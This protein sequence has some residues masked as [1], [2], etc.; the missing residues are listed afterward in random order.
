MTVLKKEFTKIHLE[1]CE[2]I[3]NQVYHNFNI[4]SGNNTYL[5][6]NK[7]QQLKNT[8]AKNSIL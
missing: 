7:I 8:E 2:F 5:L 6:L 4:S 3:K 1:D